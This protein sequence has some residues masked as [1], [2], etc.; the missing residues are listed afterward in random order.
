MS[1][2]GDNMATFFKVTKEDV[3][4]VSVAQWKEMF[5]AFCPRTHLLQITPEVL[6]YL[7]SDGMVMPQNTPTT[8]Q[9]NNFKQKGESLESEDDDS[10]SWASVSSSEE[11]P[12]APSQF[13]QNIGRRQNGT[14]DRRMNDIKDDDKFERGNG[15][16]EE[17]AIESENYVFQERRNSVS[18]S[19]EDEDEDDGKSLE[20]DKFYEFDSYIEDSIE[21]LG[22]AVIAKLNRKSPKVRN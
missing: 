13:L 14:D 2:N 3:E 15:Y 19:D 6:K 10:E 5:A 7:K 17:K 18:S 22:G 20:V 12:S 9:R 4:A 21:E 16:S 1:G 8:A 11:L